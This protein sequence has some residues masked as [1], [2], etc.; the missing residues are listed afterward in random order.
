MTWWEGN[1]LVTDRMQALQF[2]G[3]ENCAWHLARPSLIETCDTNWVAGGDCAILHFVIEDEGEHAIE[4]FGCI[5]SKFH[6]LFN[7]NITFWNWYDSTHQW[8]YDFAIGMRLE[9]IGVL[10]P[11]SD[12]S[13]VIDLSIDCESNCL[14]LVSERLR[15]AVYTDNAQTLVCE[16]CGVLGVSTYVGVRLFES[17]LVLLAI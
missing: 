13:V 5:D 15:A 3:E 12:K 17:I 7:I 16:D 6:V 9:V 10:E 2:R 8:D 1:N 4:V 11:L 14:I